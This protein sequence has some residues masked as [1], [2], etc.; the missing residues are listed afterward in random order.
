MILHMFFGCLNPLGFQGLR[1]PRKPT[2]D[3]LEHQPFEDASPIKNGD[4]P[5][6]H[7]SLPGG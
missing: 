3:W 2:N 6:C 1:A 7:V 4:F 5:A